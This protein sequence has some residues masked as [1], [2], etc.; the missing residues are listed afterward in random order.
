MQ[1]QIALL[2][3]S[4][5]CGWS[6]V[7][8]VLASVPNLRIAGEASD[9]ARAADLAVRLQPS[10]IV[11][12]SLLEGNSTSRLLVSLQKDVLPNSKFIVIAKSF[13]SQ[14]AREFV[15]LSFSAMLLWSEF[16]VQTLSDS[17]TAAISC[18]IIVMSR[19]VAE[20]FTTTPRDALAADTS[21]I[22]LNCRERAILRRL[23]EGLTYEEIA[24]SE[25]LSRRSVARSVASLEAALNSPTQFTLGRKVTQLGL[26]D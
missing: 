14:N 7:R 22:R 24:R 11:A 4:D 12:P 15:E 25:Q 13:Q 10:V 9:S 26:L 6:D 20:M 3:R 21:P 5:D 18:D 8:L 23:S 17:L 1:P 16:T 19:T 2:V